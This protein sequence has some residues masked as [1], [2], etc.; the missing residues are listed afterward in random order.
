MKNSFQN[1]DRIM[2]T[3]CMI[4]SFKF[5]LRYVLCEA[6]YVMGFYPSTQCLLLVS[7]SSSGNTSSIV[8][9]GDSRIQTSCKYILPLFGL[10]L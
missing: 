7:S 3:N 8:C 10:S 9:D 2:S 1:R 4:P 5:E 6:D